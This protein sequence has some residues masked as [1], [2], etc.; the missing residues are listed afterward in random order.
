MG[1]RRS[2]TDA[3]DDGLFINFHAARALLP[4]IKQ[5]PATFTWRRRTQRCGWAR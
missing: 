2:H 3:F 1:R 4:G 5:R